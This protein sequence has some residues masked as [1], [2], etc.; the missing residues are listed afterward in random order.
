MAKFWNGRSNSE[1]WEV[2]ILVEISRIWWALQSQRAFLFIANDK[3]LDWKLIWFMLS[4]SVDAMAALDTNCFASWI[5]DSW[6]LQ[7][8]KLNRGS[9][10]RLTLNHFSFSVLS[11][12]SINFGLISSICLW[13]LHD[14]SFLRILL[15]RNA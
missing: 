5:G 15:T 6:L 9:S 4:S 12:T 2:V 3:I 8:I 14:S 7:E 11:Q 13:K 10:K 1:T